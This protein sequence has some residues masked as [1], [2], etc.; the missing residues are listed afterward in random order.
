[1]KKIITAIFLALTS[2]SYGTTSSSEVNTFVRN[3]NKKLPQKHNLRFGGVGVSYPDDKLLEIDLSYTGCFSADIDKARQLVVELMEAARTQINEDRSMKQII[4]PSPFPTEQI[5]LSI[6]F[7]DKNGGSLLRQE[8][9]SLAVSNV[10]RGIVRYKIK[11]DEYS[12]KEIYKEPYSEAYE[13]VM[14]QKGRP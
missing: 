13:K 12:F 14:G 11:Q 9:G 2:C 8:S 5:T 1:M 7:I 6:G 10:V 4:D 3:F